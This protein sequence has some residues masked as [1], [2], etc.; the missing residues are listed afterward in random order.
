MIGF[1]YAIGDKHRVKIGWSQ[2]PIRRLD[3]IRS[4]CPD[5]AHLLGL[6]PATRAQE[7]EAHKLLEPWR[8]QRE[9]FR[10]EGAVAAFIGMLPR[11][12]PEPVQPK[13]VTGFTRLA[14]F[15]RSG[16]LSDN[17]VAAAIGRS[18]VSVSRYRRRL[19]RP[20]WQ[21]IT[22]IEVFTKGAVGPSDWKEVDT[23]LDT[24]RKHEAAE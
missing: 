13:P 11:P 10:R 19:R 4:D 9:W 16:Q 5:A 17:D 6:I 23:P 22:N 7:E 14:D 12:H 18:R 3:K 2:D 15:M 21:A 1:V 8:I 20:D 24:A